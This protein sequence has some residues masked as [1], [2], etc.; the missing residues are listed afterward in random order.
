MMIGVEYVLFS[1]K[2]LYTIDGNYNV[3]HNFITVWLLDNAPFALYKLS[4]RHSHDIV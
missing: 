1:E 4:S 3:M 2:L